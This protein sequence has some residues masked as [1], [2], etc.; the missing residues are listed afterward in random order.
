VREQKQATRR[1]HRLF[2]PR[3]LRKVSFSSS[4][5]LRKERE[6]DKIPLPQQQ[7]EKTFVLFCALLE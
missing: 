2:V 7:Q 5:A 3:A 4:R 1:A 6:K